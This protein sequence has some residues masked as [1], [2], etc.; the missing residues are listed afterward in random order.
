MRQN[1]ETIALLHHATGTGK[2]VTAIMDAKR[3]GGRVLFLA[4]TKELVLQSY[5]RF[6]KLWP[7][8]TIG[9]YFEQEKITNTHIVCGSIQSVA[10][11]LED[12]S[13]KD[14]SYL[15]IDEAHHAAS[16]IY[17]KV[18]AYFCPQF[19]LGLT[20]TPER[21]DEKEILEIF[22]NTA[23]RLDIQT[24]VEIGELS[25]VRCIRI[26]TNIDLT[27]VRFNAT[28]YNITDLENKI[29]LP[30]RNILI[31]NTLLR[32]V[33]KKRTVIF[34]A[35]VKHAE[36]ISYILRQKG[37]NAVAVSGKMKPLERKEFQ[38]K[39]IN[40]EITVLCACDLLNEGWDCPEI[41]VL[42]MARP[43]LSKTLYLQ[44]LGRGMRLSP[45]KECLFVF[46]FVDN[47]NIYNTPWSLHRIF[48]LKKYKPGHLAIAPQKQITIDE[49][50]YAQGEKPA[51]L[52]DW[53]VTAIDYEVVDLF[54][55]QEEATNMISQMEFVRRV[56]V[57]YET[58]EQYIRSGKIIPDLSVPLSQNRIFKYFKEET[59]KKYT[60]KF[61]WTLI[62]SKNKKN[63]FIQTIEHMDMLYSYKPLLVKA[64]LTHAD[65]KGQVYLFNIVE[66]FRNFYE[67]RRQQKKIVEKR[68]SIFA[69]L[70]Y[71][72]KEALKNIL[73]NPFRRFEDMQFFSH[74]KTLG[75]IKVD[76]SIWKN[77][78]QKE[79]EYINSICDK[80]LT[81]YF[82]KL[83]K[84]GS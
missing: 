69:K 25:P 1:H 55:W 48:K 61:N 12:F 83:D 37:I 68:N 35:S 50:L 11:N 19:T 74:T 20:A 60:E 38:R 64:I 53:P 51:I 73:A 49:E 47:A 39:F 30:E 10:L 56:N 79:K 27:K 4:H 28:K 26:H 44:Q 76:E 82:L 81:E 24:A 9:R 13:S 3:C 46:D 57:Q 18:L 63:I 8:V 65:N 80:K 84:K 32:Y 70:E 42:F 22:K 72:D 14:F 33:P 58:I 59:I 34:C 31:A 67:K 5:D 71:S 43:T 7:D 45:G 6:K 52:L 29:F 15:I 54:N 40:R 21:T 62:T 2:T 23:H 78:T 36:N 17:Q 77:L 75:V 16:E 41:E 66:Y